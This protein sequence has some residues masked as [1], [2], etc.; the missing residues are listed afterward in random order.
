MRKIALVLSVLILIISSCKEEKQSYLKNARAKKGLQYEL[1]VDEVMKLPIS[2]SD[3]FSWYTKEFEN[4]QGTYIFRENGMLTE[5]QVYNLDEIGEPIKKSFFTEGPNGI[6]DGVGLSIIPLSLNK[7]YLTNRHNELFLMEYDSIL[8]RYDLS[9]SQE[10]PAMMPTNH[11]KTIMLKDS[12]FGF[13]QYKQM[14]INTNE[15]LQSSIFALFDIP[16][17][18]FKDASITFPQSYLNKCWTAQMLFPAYTYNNSTDKL[19]FGFPAEKNLYSYDYHDDTI[20]EINVPYTDYF[21]E[22]DSF[23]ECDEV[24]QKIDSYFLNT[25]NYINIIYDKYREI[26]YRMFFLPPDNIYKGMRGSHTHKRLGIIVYDKNFDVIH[27]KLFEPYTYFPSDYF[28]NEDGLWLSMN[29]PESENFNENYF[30][31]ALLKLR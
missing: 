11:A 12:I 3:Y 27:E 16:E 24:P 6:R 1:V 2:T 9:N 26:Y 7:Y 13:G 23:K 10:Y 15:Y 21:R 25:P 20:E 17:N 30:Q 8:K 14:N 22:V 28:V 29:N 4:D 5:I 18:K 19:I 31:F